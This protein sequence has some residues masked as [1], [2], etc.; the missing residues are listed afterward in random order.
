MFAYCGNNPVVRTDPTGNYPTDWDLVSNQ[1]AGEE[2]MEWL[3]GQDDDEVG[4][5]G[6][7]TLDAKLKRTYLAFFYNL[8]FELGLGV[9]V[10]H[11]QEVIDAGLGYTIHF[12]IISLQYRDGAWDVG[13]RL[14]A[15]LYASAAQPFEFGTGLDGTFN[16][17]GAPHSDTWIGVNH[18]QQ[19]V[20]IIS[21]ADYS[22][23]VGAN[24]RVGF[25][26]FTFLVMMTEIWG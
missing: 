3:L 19:S 1:E 5:D 8:E 24:V 11:V 4:S 13:Q 14:V 25:D 21:Y 20:T 9:G 22:Y 10:G 6:N 26:S 23:F 16:N 12:D 15:S 7:L 18:T 17:L 2:F